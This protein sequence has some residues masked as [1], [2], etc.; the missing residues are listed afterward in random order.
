MTATTLVNGPCASVGVQA[1]APVTGLIVIPAGGDLSVKV[2]EFVGTSV[3]LADAETLSTVSSSIV[4]FAGTVSCGAVLTSRTV[5]V[6]VLVTLNCW[7]AKA[8]AL[9]S[10][11]TTLMTLVIGPWASV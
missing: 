1:M 7:F 3:S 9:V 6:K 10:V 11:T 5:T 2:S 4:W 8:A